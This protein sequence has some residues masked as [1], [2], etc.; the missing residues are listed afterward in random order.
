MRKINSP[1]ERTLSNTIAT[2]FA[3][4]I[5]IGVPILSLQQY[6]HVFKIDK[7]SS[8]PLATFQPR[9]IDKTKSSIKLFEEPLISVTFD[10]GWEVTYSDAMP[11]L[12]KYGIH[13]TQYVLTGVEDDQKYLSWKQIQAIHETGHEIGCHSHTHP[14]LRV[15]SNED[16]YTQVHGCKTE[17]NNRFGE[18]ASFASPYGAFDQ[19]TISVIR[20]DFT[21]Q[22]NTNGDSSNGVTDD[23]VN[24]AQNF[25]QFNIIGMTIKRDTSVAEIK[26]LVNYTIEHNGWLVLTYHQA[27]DGGSKYGIDIQSLEAQLK[28]INQAPARVVTVGEVIRSWK[29][30]K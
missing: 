19:R 22:R 29:S 21:S 18:T 24:L 28:V 3:C 15:L 23:D 27:D 17:L 14:D 4:L 12:Q 16:L 30:T 20:N 2:I 6:S 8:D 9:A 1:R 11:L 10:D 7:R 5:V 25:N 26:S 13:T